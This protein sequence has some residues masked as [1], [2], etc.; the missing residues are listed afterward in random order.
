MTNWVTKNCCACFGK[1][2]SA[3]HTQTIE[4]FSSG[5]IAPR[6][7]CLVNFFKHPVTTSVAGASFA[8]GTTGCTIGG[9]ATLTGNTSGVAGM[10]A[11]GTVP[12]IV[13]LAVG[14][15]GVALLAGWGI[16]CCCSNSEVTVPADHKPLAHKFISGLSTYDTNEASKGEDSASKTGLV[17]YESQ[18]SFSDESS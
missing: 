15:A 13:L 16:A 4:E 6:Q 12:W 1:Q 17:T 7:S 10:I 14:G 9:V 5:K 11:V 18:S 8:T 2:P 3:K